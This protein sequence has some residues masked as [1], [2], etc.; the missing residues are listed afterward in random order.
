MLTSVYNLS[1]FLLGILCYPYSDLSQIVIKNKSIANYHKNQCSRCNS[2][3]RLR[4]EYLRLER[5]QASPYQN[6]CLLSRLCITNSWIPALVSGICYRSVESQICTYSGN[7]RD[8]C[9]VQGLANH[10]LQSKCALTLVFVNKVL[11]GHSCG[12]SF[13]F[14]CGCFCTVMAEQDGCHSDCMA[15]K[16]EVFI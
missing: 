10:G 12:Y 13:C 15:P 5:T 3:W 9:F 8:Y 7:L 16:P 11:L 1:E 2:R 4:S 14:A 6:S